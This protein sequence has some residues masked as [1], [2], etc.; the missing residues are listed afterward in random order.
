MYEYINI[1]T[2]YNNIYTIN[3]YIGIITDKRSNNILF[4]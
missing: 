2:N 3:K 1:W 4:V